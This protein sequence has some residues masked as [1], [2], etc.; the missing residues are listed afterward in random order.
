MI[1]LASFA[2]A[3][4]VVVVLMSTAATARAGEGALD[5]ESPWAAAQ[6]AAS[7]SCVVTEILAT[8]DKKGVD[9]RLEKFKRKLTQAPFAS[10]D[11]FRQLGEQT[12]TAP[13]SKASTAKLQ[14]GS[15]LTVLYKG[16]DVTKGAK[17]RLRFEITVDN[18]K[19]KRVVTTV[20]VF[21]AGDVQFPM[22][23]VQYQNGTYVL[24]MTCQ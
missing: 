16:T 2:L 17:P 12:I 10:F 9:P 18:D 15:T 3:A 14:P 6:S 8:N 24:A 1:R 22:A 19:G 23:G 7:S 21:D 13:Q 11:T 20:L 5:E 4:V